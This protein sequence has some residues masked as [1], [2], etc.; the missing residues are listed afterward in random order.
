MSDTDKLLERFRVQ[1]EPSGV[2]PQVAAQIAEQVLAMPNES[3]AD[4]I[5]QISAWLW[6]L[7]S[8]AAADA[9]HRLNA[10]PRREEVSADTGTA[11]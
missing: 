11:A 8:V 4:R 5:A 7:D 3:L 1:L 2:D 6:S 10:A 9:W